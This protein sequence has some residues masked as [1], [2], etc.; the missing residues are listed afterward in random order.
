MNKYKLF[1]SRYKSDKEEL[2][3]E[4]SKIVN[5]EINSTSKWTGTYNISFI[6]NEN[7]HE[8]YN[9]TN[10]KYGV[11]SVYT[12]EENINKIFNK[13]SKEYNCI[14]II[15]NEKYKAKGINEYSN[16]L[17]NL[18]PCCIYEDDI[19]VALEYMNNLLINEKELK[20]YEK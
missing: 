12:E 1:I 13:L 6:N 20:T 10:E 15:N 14:L 17:L 4:I 16:K 19:P 5:C 9:I 8:H 7:K 18:I 3:F 11:L 2:G